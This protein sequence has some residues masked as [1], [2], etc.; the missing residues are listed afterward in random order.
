M[1]RHWAAQ[2]RSRRIRNVHCSR[3]IISFCFD[4]FPRSALTEGGAVLGHFGVK[5][6]YYVSLGLMDVERS[7]VGPMFRLDD[8]RAVMAAGHELGCHTFDH[9]DAWTCSV[10]QFMDSISRNGACLARLGCGSRFRSFSYPKGQATPGTKTAIESRF[11]CC[12]GIYPGINASG[13]DVNL[14]KA[15][16]IYGH[17]ASLERLHKLIRANCA[18]GGWLVFY[19][20]DVSTQPSRFGC[21]TDFLSRVIDASLGAGATILPVSSAFDLAFGTSAGK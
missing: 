8:L 10:A 5:A 7:S 13:A 3:P 6:T 15:C 9:A 19:T 12:R 18:V 1:P 2:T 20:H 17:G 16:S 4:D 14:L 21:T 11:E